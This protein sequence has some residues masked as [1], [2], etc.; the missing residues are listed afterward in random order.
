MVSAINVSS[1]PSVAGQ[2]GATSAL[3]ETGDFDFLSYLLGLQATTSEENSAAIDPGLLAP[4]LNTEEIALAEEGASSQKEKELSQWN[5]IF[6]GQNRNQIWYS[7][8][9]FDC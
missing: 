9:S 5:Q 4:R 2:S 3:S 1:N 7:Q 8:I 6:P